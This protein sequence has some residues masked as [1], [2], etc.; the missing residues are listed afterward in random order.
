VELFE[1]GR[2]GAEVAG[3]H[4]SKPLPG[5]GYHQTSVNTAAGFDLPH[6]RL[7]EGIF[8]DVVAWKALTLP[9]DWEN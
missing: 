4:A 8:V 9:S 6:G 3:N 1:C 7:S 5:H 2:L